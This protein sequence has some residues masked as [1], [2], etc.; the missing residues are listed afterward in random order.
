MKVD[1]DKMYELYDAGL[2]VDEIAENCACS[3]NYTL[4]LLQ[5]KYG[6]IGKIDTGKIKALWRAGWSINSIMNE[7][8][9]SEDEIRKVVLG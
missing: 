4:Y 5:K 1:K 8:N 7:M 3:R 6:K 9:V 2:S